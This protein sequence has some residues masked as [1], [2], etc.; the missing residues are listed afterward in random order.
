MS[1]AQKLRWKKLV[2]H[3]RYVYDELEIVR[4]I[5]SNASMDFQA[6]YEDFCRRHDL[7][8]AELN[9]QHAERVREL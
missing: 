6:Y 7:D 1:A 2:N 9:R 5:G 3:L 4:E 8:I